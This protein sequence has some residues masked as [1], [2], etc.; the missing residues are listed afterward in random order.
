MLSLIAWHILGGLSSELVTLNVAALKHWE[1]RGGH[2][3]E[4][5]NKQRDHKAEQ[6]LLAGSGKPNWGPIDWRSGGQANTQLCK[7]VLHS[8]I[9]HLQL[10]LWM[11]AKSNLTRC[12]LS[13]YIL[14]KHCHYL[15]FW[16]KNCFGEKAHVSCC[17]CFTLSCRVVSTRTRGSSKVHD[18]CEVVSLQWQRQRAKSDTSV[19]M[20]NLQLSRPAVITG[21]ASSVLLTASLSH[22]SAAEKKKLF[23]VAM[24]L[25]TN[26]MTTAFDLKMTSI[27][28]E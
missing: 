22:R 9:Q 4:G 14:Q 20:I 7:R 5:E 13:S 21:T 25:R 10:S 8:S 19:F 23:C 6:T 15:K 2:S 27:S 26:T 3:S 24:A 1:R 18:L 16:A 12:A 17:T 11:A 28:I